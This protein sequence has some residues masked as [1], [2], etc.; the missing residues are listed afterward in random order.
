[1]QDDIFTAG[2]SAAFLEFPTVQ[3]FL[4]HDTTVIEN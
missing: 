4:F 2:L 3:A 1:M